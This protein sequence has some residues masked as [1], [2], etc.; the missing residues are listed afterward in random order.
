MNV[1]GTERAELIFYLCARSVR[2]FVYME[3]EEKRDQYL[4]MAPLLYPLL[5]ALPDY[6]TEDQLDEVDFTTSAAV[7]L[8]MIAR[9]QM[10]PMGFTEDEIRE[11]ITA[12]ALEAMARVHLN[13]ARLL[14]RPIE[15]YREL[16]SASSESLD[17][18]LARLLE[19]S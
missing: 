9:E 18:E 2:G 15:D 14:I 6:C 10:L 17:E 13:F 5:E 3:P 12:D 16:Q 19:D 8:V 4:R 7:T 1:D 11:A